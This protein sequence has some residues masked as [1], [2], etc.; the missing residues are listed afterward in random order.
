MEKTRASAFGFIILIL[1]S[2]VWA[3]PVP[4]TGMTKCY[5]VAGNALPDSTTP[6]SWL[7]TMSLG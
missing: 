1:I 6:G 2:D 3:A 4:D 7:E 5:N